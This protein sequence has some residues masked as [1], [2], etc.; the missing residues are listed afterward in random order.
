MQNRTTSQ[1]RTYFTRRLCRMNRTDPESFWLTS[2]SQLRSGSQR[3]HLG[4]SANRCIFILQI[5]M[6]PPTVSVL[7]EQNSQKWRA[8][9]YSGSYWESPELWIYSR[10]FLGSSEMSRTSKTNYQ[11]TNYGIWISQA[12]PLGL[13]EIIQAVF[14]TAPS[15]NLRRATIRWIV[16]QNA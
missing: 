4:E 7:F 15:A 6:G 14:Q 12:K 16:K 5:P 8:N 11:K 9:H 13:V 1:G 10:S 3:K 2:L